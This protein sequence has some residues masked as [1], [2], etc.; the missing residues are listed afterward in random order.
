MRSAPARPRPRRSPPSGYDEGEQR[1]TR[2]AVCAGYLAIRLGTWLDGWW[3]G[4]V[5]MRGAYAINLYLKRDVGLTGWGW[6]F[7]I[8][9][10]Q[11][12]SYEVVSVGA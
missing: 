11:G 12:V 4:V 3:G 5:E 1:E 6:L 8:V 7:S 2:R 10:T 9:T